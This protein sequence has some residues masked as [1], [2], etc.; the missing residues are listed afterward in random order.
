LSGIKKSP[1]FHLKNPLRRAAGFCFLII[2]K[3]V[4]S[5]VLD[6]IGVTF[7]LATLLRFISYTIKR[8]SVIDKNMGNVKP[9]TP[10]ITI[11]TI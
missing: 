8:K 11:I 3:I 2:V 1:V 6:L 5:G 10:E 9:K 7:L 4:I